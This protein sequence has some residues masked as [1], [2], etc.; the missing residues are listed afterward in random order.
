MSEDRSKLKVLDLF[1]GILSAASASDLSGQAALK[2]SPSA[3]L[4]TSRA[5]SSPNTGRR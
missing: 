5:A 2:P 3:K 4:R 1:S